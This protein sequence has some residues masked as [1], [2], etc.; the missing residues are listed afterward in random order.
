MRDEIPKSDWKHFKIIRELALQRFCERALNE[1]TE[2][3]ADES[4]SQHGR[5]VEVYR[6]IQTCDEKIAAAFDNLS[7]SRMM[8]QL[9]TIQSLDLIEDAELESFTQETRDKLKLFASI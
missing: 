7:R 9:A 4:A 5:Y 8:V 6:K 2:I 1:L 3:A